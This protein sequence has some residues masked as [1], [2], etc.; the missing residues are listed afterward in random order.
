MSDRDAGRGAPVAAMSF[1]IDPWGFGTL[2]AVG[3]P[4]LRASAHW[5]LA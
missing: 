1:G 3:T 2:W 5:G 4:Q